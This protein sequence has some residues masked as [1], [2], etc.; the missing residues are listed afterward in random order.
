MPCRGLRMIDEM[1]DEMVGLFP[2]GRW[3]TPPERVFAFLVSRIPSVFLLEYAMCARVILLEYSAPEV[4]G[5]HY[6]LV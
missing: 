1:V 6:T 3:H 4:T 5:L 2:N